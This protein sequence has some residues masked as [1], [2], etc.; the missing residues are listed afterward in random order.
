MESVLITP[1]S[2]TYHNNNTKI[3]K[4]KKNKKYVTR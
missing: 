4:N 3:N 1:L 2:F